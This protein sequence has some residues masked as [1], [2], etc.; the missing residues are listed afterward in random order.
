MESGRKTPPGTELTTIQNSHQLIAQAFHHAQLT[1]APPAQLQPL[2]PWLEMDVFRDE[3]TKTQHAA[4]SLGMAIGF[5]GAYS[6]YILGAGFGQ[7]ISA[8]LHTNSAGSSFLQIYFGAVAYTP[9]AIL[10]GL[11]TQA[12]FQYYVGLVQHRPEL[13]T[14]NDMPWVRYPAAFVSHFLSL[15][16]GV[17]FV[18]LQ[19]EELVPLT[20]IDYIVP[21]CAMIASYC[22][23]IYAENDLKESLLKRI[24]TVTPELKT[25][26]KNL[27][28]R[29]DS[30]IAAVNTMPV[31]DV[32]ELFKQLKEKVMGEN[33]TQ[34]TV[35]KMKKLFANSSIVQQDVVQAEKSSFT[36][37][38]ETA[39]DFLGYAF[40]GASTYVLY[41]LAMQT[42]DSAYENAEVGALAGVLAL[43]TNAVF[44]AML[45]QKRAAAIYDPERSGALNLTVKGSITQTLAF[46]AAS[47]ST[48]LAILGANNTFTTIMAIV[49]FIGGGL[50]KELGLR[51]LADGAVSLFENTFRADEPYVQRKKLITMLRKIRHA[52]PLM[53]QDQALAFEAALA[54]AIP[55]RTPA[56]E[57]NIR[58]DEAS[59]QAATLSIDARTV[60]TIESAT[61]VRINVYDKKEPDNSTSPDRIIF[62]GQMFS[63][64]SKIS[65]TTVL[66]DTYVASELKHG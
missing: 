57:L 17:P 22:A 59:D 1:H 52:I 38:K 45:G 44:T 7:I 28:A 46:C 65:Q 30:T 24:E 51:Y 19:Y 23:V 53:H 40:G 43:T 54:A 64:P 13:P 11:P 36:I 12:R 34:H 47:P 55:A 61:P 21:V 32:N 63:P 8:P 5:A 14:K 6:G 26:Y 49:T 56:S 39:R 48:Y 37:L 2:L 58:I 62:N 18:N 41:G 33:A 27:Y 9:I 29:I 42:S 60:T 15:F 4:G 10:I 66:P 16:A 31:T 50:S 25:A 3:K 35:T 20:A